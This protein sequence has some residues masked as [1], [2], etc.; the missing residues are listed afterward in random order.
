MV[1]MLTKMFD[2]PFLY[3]I[4]KISKLHTCSDKLFGHI[5]LIHTR[6]KNTLSEP[7]KQNYIAVPAVIARSIVAVL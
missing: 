1:K 7:P 3:R 5:C 6:L 2:F 4:N